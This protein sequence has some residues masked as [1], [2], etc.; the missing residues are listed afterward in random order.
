MYD[1]G[2]DTSCLDTTK[3]DPRK[4][5][6]CDV[7]CIESQAYMNTE[8]SDYTMGHVSRYCI[9]ICLDTHVSLASEK[10]DAL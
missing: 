4:V 7:T 8:I 9:S 6:H 5:K 2:N 3:L 10:S 1:T